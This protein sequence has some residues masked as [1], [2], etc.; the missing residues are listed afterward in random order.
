MNIVIGYLY[1]FK[2]LVNVTDIYMCLLMEHSSCLIKYLSKHLYL[3]YA[4]LH[5]T[6][7]TFNISVVE[8]CII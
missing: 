6:L 7:S 4:C 5:S 3:M 2:W 1:N 8:V